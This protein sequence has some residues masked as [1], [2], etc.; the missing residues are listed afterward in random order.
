M[1]N[2][3]HRNRSL[4][5]NKST[6]GNVTYYSCSSVGVLSRIPFVQVV[7]ALIHKERRD[8]SHDK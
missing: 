5:V 2:T 8:P 3:F 1:L 6:A 4:A 7:P